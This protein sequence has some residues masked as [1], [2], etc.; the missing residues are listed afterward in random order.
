MSLPKRLYE[1]GRAV[2]D[3]HL[4]ITQVASLENMAAF[5]D[6]LNQSFPV[7]EKEAAQRELVR[8][9]YYCNPRG[10]LQYIGIS[11]NRVRAL[12]LW[13]E[14][15]SIAR[16]FGL[17]KC[18]HISWHE[19][20]NKYTVEPYVHREH[21]VPNTTNPVTPSNPAPRT[22]TTVVTAIYRRTLNPHAQV[23]QKNNKTY[24]SA[25]SNPTTST[26]PP[27]TTSI[28]DVVNATT[29]QWADQV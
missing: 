22:A 29:E 26:N 6:L 14:S 16:F 20:T 8:S 21:R 28:A 5:Q 25:V 23:Y 1:L 18:V 10:F 17:N 2:A 24:A 9:M 15:K 13:T 4:V 3:S 27:T 11:R 12:I 7:N 19:E